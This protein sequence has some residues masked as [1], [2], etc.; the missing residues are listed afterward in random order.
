[1]TRSMKRALAALISM[2]LLASSAACNPLEG[3]GDLE[4]TAVFQESSGLYVGNDVGVL[5]VP[6]GKITKIEPKGDV[7]E[8]T[9]KVT[10]P[11]IKIPA[12]AAAVIVSRS[13]ATDRYVELT[14]VYQGGKEIASGAT[15]PL[16]RTRTPV[17]FDRVLGSISDLAESLTKTPKI[18]N[19]LREVLQ[20]T[21]AAFSGNSDELR[22]AVSGMADL[23]DMVHGQR[24]DIFATMASLDT[25]SSGLVKNERLV[26]TFVHNLGGAIELL[27]S[28]RDDISRVLTSASTTIDRITKFSKE[29]RGTIKASLADVETLMHNLLDSRQDLGETIE[30][31][32]LA[33]QNIYNAHTPENHIWVRG[34]PGQLLGL[35]PLFEQLCQLIGPVCNLATFPDLSDLLGG[36][37]GGLG[38]GRTP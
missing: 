31:L 35:G 36:L 32:P 18:T 13:V 7:V 33:A 23:V 9:L 12:G 11:D 2:V 25:L 1:M 27:N 17:D 8:V 22:G 6:V 16:D 29:N 26:R 15:I 24:S 4:I 20:V 34:V 37:L 3:G 10:D 14:P 28:E 5:G 19:S 21:A 30:T 38:G